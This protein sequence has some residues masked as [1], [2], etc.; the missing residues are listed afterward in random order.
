MSLWTPLIWLAI[1][2]PLLLIAQLSTKETNPKYLI[3]FVAYF[4]ADC[5]TRVLGFEYVNLKFLN[6]NLNWSGTFLSLILALGFVFYHS[7]AIRKDLGFTTTFNKKTLKLGVLIFF[8]ILL[9]DFCFKMFLFPKGGTFDT[10]QFLFQAT[11]PGI[12]EEIVY[13]GILLWILS[14]AFCP[15]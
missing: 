13:R 5:Y 9:F 15:K 6:L 12:S 4:L 3:L 10:E 14:K 8:G 7:K 11:M 1:I 2:A